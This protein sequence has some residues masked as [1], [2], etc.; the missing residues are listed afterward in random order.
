MSPEN[1]RAASPG[2]GSKPVWLM[3]ATGLAIRVALALAFHGTGHVTLE[4]FAA[5]RV[6]AGDWHAVYEGAAPWTYPPLFLGWLAG[7]SWLSQ[8]SGVS[9][10][11]L[12]KL[13][14]A[15]ADIGLALA[16]YA[17]L[18]W[19]GAEERWRLG[20]AALVLIGPIFIATSSYHGQIDSVA[21]LFAVL[22]LMAWERRPTSSRAWEA[23]LLIGLGAAVKTVP[24]LMVLALLPYARSWREGIALVVAAIVPVGLALGPLWLAGID[25]HRVTGYVGVPAWGSLS[26]VLDPARAW[27]NIAVGADI[28]PTGGLAGD[29][30]GAARW[31]TL[32]ALVAYAGFIFRYRPALIDAAVLLWLAIFTF[33]PDFFLTYLVWGLPFFIMAGYLIEVAVLQAVLVVPTV[34]YYLSL[35][36][37]PSTAAAIAYVPFMFALWIFFACATIFLVARIATRRAAY[38]PEAQRPL[39]SVSSL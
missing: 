22:G 3:V 1:D 39:V 19:R 37:S 10:H 20:G 16:V 30:Q 2:L 18:G 6:R 38:E 13:G 29:L 24:L 27:H 9:F 21:I 14:P 31:I 12:A 28:S 7:A 26:L 17:Y 5:I 15:L 8:V 25:L 4:Q 23:G 11:A 34:A 36:P 33:S 32:G 35:W